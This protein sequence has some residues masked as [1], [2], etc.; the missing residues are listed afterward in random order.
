MNI[1]KQKFLIL[2]IIAL[3]TAPLFVRA[4]GLVPCGGPTEQPCTVLDIF[5]MI[6]RV[7]NWLI[8][9]AG[10][11]AVFQ[12][13]SAGFWLTVS[14]GN[15][16]SVTKWTK[17]LRQAIIGFFIVLGAFMFMNT[18]ANMILMS[19]CAIDFRSPW[20]YITMTDPSNV[21]NCKNP[22]NTFLNGN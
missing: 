16:E 7:T 3:L 21:S 6:A 9:M 12:I 4:A 1:L 2:S 19:K 13:V 17:A 14:A 11:Y 22:N 8:V 10:V 5:Y 15:E 20:T 18:A